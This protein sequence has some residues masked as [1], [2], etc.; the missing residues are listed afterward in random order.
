M[1]SA[2]S[3]GVHALVRGGEACLVTSAADVLEVVGEM[4][5]H[6]TRPT[7][8]PER[9]HD[10]LP[11]Q[12]RQVLEAVP[13]RSAA[14]ESSISRIAGVGL[15]ETRSALTELA[16]QGLVVA[17]GRGWRLARRPRNETTDQ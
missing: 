3:E 8:G 1:T 17:A 7:R 11:T 5:Q 2:T 16:N 10:R 14:P 4:G 13:A 15:P 9:V 12:Q 6:L